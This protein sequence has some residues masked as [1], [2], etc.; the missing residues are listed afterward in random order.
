MPLVLQSSS[1][2][3]N[4]D[5]DL[6]RE[7]L[8]ILN[9]DLAPE[10]GYN[11]YFDDFNDI[12]LRVPSK[13]CRVLTQLFSVNDSAMLAP[14]ECLELKILLDGVEVPNANDYLDTFKS[15]LNKAIDEN[16]KLHVLKER[17]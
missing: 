11:Y 15:Y 13:G 9:Q 5:T 16:L 8:Q 3:F 14:S 7:E 17:G 4:L 1:E 6:N 10:F 2:L 12:R